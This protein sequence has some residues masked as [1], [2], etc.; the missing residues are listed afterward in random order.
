MIDF[1]SYLV[2]RELTNLVIVLWV[3]SFLQT[4]NVKFCTELRGFE[5]FLL[6]R[7]GVSRVVSVP[8]VFTKT[9]NNC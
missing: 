1:S 7:K 6:K 2:A 5:E 8:V 9:K 3:N 4:G